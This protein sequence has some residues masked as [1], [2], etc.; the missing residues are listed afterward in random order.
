MLENEWKTISK[1][2]DYFNNTFDKYEGYYHEYVVMD[3]LNSVF[4][5][6]PIKW[7]N[8]VQLLDDTSNIANST[9]TYN[10]YYN[11]LLKIEVIKPK[12]CDQINF[13][14]ND[15]S[16]SIIKFFDI[17]FISIS[18]RDNKTFK[19]LASNSIKR[20]MN[21]ILTEMDRQLKREKINVH[22]CTLMYLL[23]KLS[24]YGIV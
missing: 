3:G 17:N 7:D 4:K 9:D 24:F 15:T 23:I 16:K 8:F 10:R 1:E 13:T 12:N 19:L 6:I 11:V 5:G 2:L 21:I 14:V 20:R 18:F 22:Q